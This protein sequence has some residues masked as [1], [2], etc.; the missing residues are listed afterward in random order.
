MNR[1]INLSR[2]VMVSPLDSERSDQSS[3]LGWTSRFIFR[4]YIYF[5]YYLFLSGVIE[6]NYFQFNQNRKRFLMT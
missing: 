3:N 1:P 2:G 4:V 5:N 6:Y